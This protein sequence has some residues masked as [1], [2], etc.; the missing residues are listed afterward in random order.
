MYMPIYFTVHLLNNNNTLHSS[1]SSSSNSSNSNN[2]NSNA[3]SNNNNNNNN[4]NSRK[5]RMRQR[6]LEN[7]ISRTML[8][9]RH[10]MRLK[11]SLRPIT[12]HHNRFP[13]CL[14]NLKLSVRTSC[15]R[16]KPSR[17]FLPT[18]MA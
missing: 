2:N 10:S 5:P 12:L 7:R 16:I 8:S 18:A 6:Q 15:G 9:L 14:R 3:S 11:A 4:N 1:S 13:V 17:A